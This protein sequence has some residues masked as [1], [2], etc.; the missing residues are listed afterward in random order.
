MIKFFNQ[1]LFILFA[2]FTLY[3]GFYEY[4]GI[5]VILYALVG[6]YIAGYAFM[7]SRS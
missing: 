4:E 3:V 7:K 1:A 6:V 2:I 5:S